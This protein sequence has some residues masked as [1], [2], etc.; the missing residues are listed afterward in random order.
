[1][2][3]LGYNPLANSMHKEWN[4]PTLE[5]SLS[6]TTYTTLRQAAERRSQPIEDLVEDALNAFLPLS[7]SS[8]TDAGNG[9]SAPASD[10][11]RARIHT[12]AE[13]WWSLPPTVRR[14]Y[15]KDYVAVHNGQVVDHDGDRLALYRRIRTRFGDV[16]VLI[17]P[18]N[19][20]SPRE[21][22][23]LSPRLDRPQ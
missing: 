10:W 15:G 21:F 22:Q 5:L 16:P 14:K 13:A 20:S 1:M 18:A 3:L 12:E 17:T 11:R 19:A 8:E 6:E 2:A 4:M 9:L 7:S 23:V